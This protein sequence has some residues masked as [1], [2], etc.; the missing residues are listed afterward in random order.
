VR[1]AEISGE[2]DA[3]AVVEGERRRRPAASRFRAAR[4]VDEA[5]GE[6]RVDALRD[7]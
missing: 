4:L 1:G 2:N 5:V 3:G 6:Q 7:G